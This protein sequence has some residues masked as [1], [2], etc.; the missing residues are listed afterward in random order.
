MQWSH[1]HHHLFAHAFFYR[2]SHCQPW[3]L[4]HICM[5]TCIYKYTPTKWM[6]SNNNLSHHYQHIY[7][8]IFVYSYS[9]NI[10][11]VILRIIKRGIILVCRHTDRHVESTVLELTILLCQSTRLAAEMTHAIATIASFQVILLS[12]FGSVAARI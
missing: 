1:H 10:L 11:E 9:I 5:P 2:W 8:E 3:V 4:L 6:T 7:S 12:Q